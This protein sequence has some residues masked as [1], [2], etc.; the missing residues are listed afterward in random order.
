MGEDITG[1][2]LVVDDDPTVA[3]V[4][5]RYLVRDGHEVECVADGRDALRSAEARPPD[6]VVLDLMLP[7][8]GGLEVCRRLRETSAVPVVMLTALG[9]ETDRLAGLELGADDYVTKPFS[10]RELA[11][12]VRSVLRRARG[13]LNPAGRGPARLDDGGLVVDLGA[14][15]AAL[16]G[17]LLS[18]TAREFDLLAYLMRHPRRAFTRDELLEH[19]WGWSFGDASTVTVHVRRLREKIEEDPTTPRRI[20]TVWGVGY[21]YEPAV[22]VP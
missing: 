19:V 4:V 14:H 7:G 1:R 17:E 15:E 21:R 11:L 18:L 6:L 8:V 12:R 16:G 20:V 22:A 2:I 13:G 5:M 10:P 3:E 9:E